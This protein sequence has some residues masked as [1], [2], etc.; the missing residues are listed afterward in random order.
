MIGPQQYSF[1][2]IAKREKVG[3]IKSGFWFWDS[4]KCQ[5]SKEQLLKMDI[6]HRFIQTQLRVL[7]FDDKKKMTS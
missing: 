2:K 3:S 5:S 7:N 6:L 4:Q 1:E